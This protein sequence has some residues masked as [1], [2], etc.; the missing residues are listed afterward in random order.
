MLVVSASKHF[1]LLSVLGNG[2]GWGKEGKG[3]YRLCKRKFPV[4]RVPIQGN[5]IRRIWNT[6]L[7]FSVC[8]NLLEIQWKENVVKILTYRYSG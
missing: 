8:L 6:R 2:S 4:R 3:V 5:V 1:F 7:P